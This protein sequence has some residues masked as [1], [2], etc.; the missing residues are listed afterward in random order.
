MMQG[1]AGKGADGDLVGD[2]QASHPGDA[3]RAVLVLPALGQREVQRV[4]PVGERGVG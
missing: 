1:G 4:T 2:S 3:G